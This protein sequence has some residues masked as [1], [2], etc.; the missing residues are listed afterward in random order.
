MPT[1]AAAP[2]PAVSSRIRDVVVATR[3]HATELWAPVPAVGCSC[4]SCRE[5]VWLAACPAP[6]KMQS[7]EA[8]TRLALGLAPSILA[9]VAIV[10]ALLN[11]VMPRRRGPSFACVVARV[12]AASQSGG[13]GL[14]GSRIGG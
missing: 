14:G 1:T 13:E 6:S 5:G 12:S 10:S 7:T 2:G 4:G 3:Q 9:Y 8:I 11:A